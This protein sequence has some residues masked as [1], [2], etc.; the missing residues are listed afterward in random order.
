MKIAIL[1]LP[2]NFN[3][4]GLLQAYALQEVLKNMGH[5][6][7]FL[8][9]RKNRNSTFKHTLVKLKWWF[10]DNIPLLLNNKNLSNLTT[11]KKNRIDSILSASFSSEQLAYQCKKEKIEAVIVGSDQIWRYTAT[12]DAEDAFLK[13]VPQGIKKIAY[14]PSFGTD[15]WEYPEEITAKLAS[16]AKEI[17]RISVRESSGIELCSNYLGVDAINL[18][19]PT[20][21]LTCNN[22]ISVLSDNNKANEISGAFAYVLDQ[23]A[24]KKDLVKSCAEHLGETNVYYIQDLSDNSVYQW[25]NAF[26]S[27][28][29]IITD[30][31]HGTVFSIIFNK[32]FVVIANNKRGRARFDSILSLLGLKDRLIDDNAEATSIVKASSTAID[33]SDVN[34]KLND[35]R[36]DH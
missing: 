18:V 35:C 15:Q 13:F 30:S 1:T 24:N 4:G 5:E 6:V 29:C 34:K 2:F 3:Y 14:A 12:P 21:L 32:P 22:Y 26:K 7:V 31:F 11:F 25:I 28:K 16:L 27:A 33:W 19:D 23:T 8:N 17:S 9:R 10:A 20:L 36:K